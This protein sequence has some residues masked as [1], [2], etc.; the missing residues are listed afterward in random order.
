MAKRFKKATIFKF[1]LEDGHFTY[2]IRKLNYHF[3]FFDYFD[4]ELDLEV[5][6]ASKELLRVLVNRPSVNKSSWIRTEIT[7]DNF[8]EEESYFVRSI[9]HRGVYEHIVYVNGS[10]QL[11]RF[12]KDLE[13]GEGWLYYGFDENNVF[14][15]QWYPD[16]SLLNGSIAL[17]NWKCIFLT[18]L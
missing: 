5:M 12:V 17:S 18:C 7:L 2:A 3:I 8:N 14:F 1:P 4:Q 13:K 6:L 15:E 16:R 10:Q 9:G 11:R